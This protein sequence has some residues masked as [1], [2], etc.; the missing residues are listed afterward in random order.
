MHVENRNTNDSEN[1]ASESASQNSEE[2]NETKEN[3]SKD[4]QETSLQRQRI[5]SLAMFEGGM[6]FREGFWRED[7]EA[8]GNMVRDKIHE[9]APE[10]NKQD[11]GWRRRTEEK[12][13]SLIFDYERKQRMINEKIYS[14]VEQ[15]TGGLTEHAKKGFDNYVVGLSMCIEEFLKAKNTTQMLTL[16]KLYNNGN[17]DGVFTKKTTDNENNNETQHDSDN[18]NDVISA[19]NGDADSMPQEQSTADTGVATDTKPNSGTNELNS[20]HIEDR[21]VQN[22]MD[23]QN[24]GAEHES[25]HLS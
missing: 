11:R 22:D 24:S 16:M 21:E 8:Y 12:V 5:I 9:S 25:D 2:S 4:E 6:R 3:R 17:L 13:K 7:V 1:S 23:R 18:S 15:S 14:L 10:K 20:G 19:D